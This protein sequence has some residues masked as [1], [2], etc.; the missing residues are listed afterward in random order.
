MRM[1]RRDD[2]ALRGRPRRHERPASSPAT[3]RRSSPSASAPPNRTST[4]SSAPRGTSS[5]TRATNTRGRATL[6]LS[7]RREAQRRKSSVAATSSRRSWSP[8][9][10][11]CSRTPTSSPTARRACATCASSSPRSRARARTGRSIWCGR[12]ASGGRSLPT[13]CYR[14]AVRNRT[15]SAWSRPRFR[16]LPPGEGRRYFHS[17]FTT[18]QLHLPRGTANGHGVAFALAEQ[19]TPERRLVAD[20]PVPHASSARR[21]RQSG[22]WPARPPRP[23][24]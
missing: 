7:I 19:R 13:A 9:P 18:V 24:R 21:L 22:R 14:P 20:A 15:W 12:R 11:R 23:R 17:T 1:D 10:A 2:D 16:E 8:S 6:V 3:A 4:A 5:L